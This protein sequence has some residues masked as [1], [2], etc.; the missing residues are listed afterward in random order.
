MA[1]NLRATSW[2]GG[3]YAVLC[4]L[5]WMLPLLNH[6][7]VES[8]AV[9]AGAGFFLGG[10]AALR[11]FGEGVPLRTVW[12]EQ[13]LWSIVP[14]LLMLLPRLWQPACALGPG[15]LFFFLF[16]PVSITLGVALAYLLTAISKG[17]HKVLFI[18]AGGL[19]LIGGVLY[20]LG[21]HPQFYTYNHVFGGVL[22]P[23][24]DETLAVRPGLFVFR[25]LTVLWAGLCITAGYRL[26]NPEAKRISVVALVL[27]LFI[28]T[29]YLCSS[30]L[31]I[32][33]SVRYLQTEFSGH[34][35]TAQFDLYYDTTAVTSS[36][37]DGYLLDHAYRYHQLAES[38]N[39]TPAQRIQS[40]LYP[41]AEMKGWLTGARQ[42]NV[43]P[44]WLSQPQTHVLLD[45][46]SYVFPHELVHA[47]SRPFGL[48]LIK[49][50]WSVGLV[51]GLAVALEPPDG[52]PS[53]H[54]QL[55]A[56]MSSADS[57]GY[58]WA[59][60]A[61]DVASRLSP[62][63]FWTGRGAVS[64]AT[65][66]SF[67]RFLIDRYGVE[68]FK[69]A[70]AWADFEVA[71]DKPVA[72]LAGEWTAFLQ[73]QPVTPTALQYI[74]NRFARLSLFEQS[75][76][77][78]TP[79]GLKAYRV[80]EAAL[81]EGDSARALDHFER[82]RS[83]RPHLAPATLRWARLALADGQANVVADTLAAQVAADS[84]RAG[85]FG[86]LL[87]DAYVL[88]GDPE[89]ARVAYAQAEAQMPVYT[90]LQRAMLT[91]HAALADAPSVMKVLV[92]GGEPLEKAGRLE[93]LAVDAPL[94]RWMQALYYA[95]AEAFEPAVRALETPVKAAPPVALLK[96]RQIWLSTLHYKMQNYTQARIHADSAR[97][98]AEQLADTDEVRRLT[99]WLNKIEWVE[100]TVN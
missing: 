58:S 31:G 88:T 67:V 46:Y 79:A 44:V 13:L 29:V 91:L 42:T 56:A 7:H 4:V 36:A 59:M 90:R 16:V 57:L 47:F 77:H 28:G 50:S 62:L 14:L 9:L 83:V 65:M 30:P 89:H 92:S 71:Y 95:E 39:T 54:A 87:G 76:P 70:Y 23:I 10:V 15:L 63:G 40:Y 21:L 72:D 32:N 99:D 52:Y 19:L 96:Q 53:P 60:L 82:L 41:D 18:S 8:S 64:Y 22:G 55:A 25:G 3:S 66:G 20:D 45:A 85:L 74:E 86:T 37:L 97:T 61:E 17:N 26:R 51:E 98:L 69:R 5:L 48:P 6:L 34:V 24:Y 12:V 100:S 78:D 81:T 33:T 2:V 80:G 68:R 38:L 94:V 1:I 35:Q 49:A 73:T 75:C 27:C 93:P 84:V 43:A 11:R